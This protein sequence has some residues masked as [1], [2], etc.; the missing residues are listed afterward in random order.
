MIETN[1]F[2]TS[3]KWRKL[4][5]TI[6]LQVRLFEHGLASSSGIPWHTV[7]IAF[8]V[9]GVHK[10][11]FLHPDQLQQFLASIFTIL[12]RDGFVDAFRMHPFDLFASGGRRGIFWRVSY[13]DF[14][15]ETSSFVRDLIV[16]VKSFWCCGLFG[17]SFVLFVLTT[18]CLQNRFYRCGKILNVVASITTFRSIL[19][20]IT[21]ILHSSRCSSRVSHS[22]RC[23]GYF[24]SLFQL[25]SLSKIPLEG[26]ETCHALN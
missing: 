25:F 10:L 7:S 16:L 3:F 5:R 18:K 17:W 6:Q 14:V 21:R 22:S 24:F 13:V 26:V 19:A 11:A 9:S 15:Q 20:F 4:P 1:A 2:T 8:V 12:R 23:S